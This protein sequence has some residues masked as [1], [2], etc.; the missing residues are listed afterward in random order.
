MN[1][2]SFRLEITNLDP[3][4]YVL[5]LTFLTTLGLAVTTA[6]AFLFATTTTG[7]E[8]TV[9]IRLYLAVLCVLC[10]AAGVALTK[11]GLLA[12]KASDLVIAF[13]GYLMVAWFT[14]TS[15]ES[16]STLLFPHAVNVTATLLT[17]TFFLLVMGCSSSLLPN[18]L[19]SPKSAIVGS[20]SMLILGIAAQS[21]ISI[22]E[23][24]LASALVGY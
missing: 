7:P 19:R 8:L 12:H 15:L 11:V 14:G 24:T 6:G 9:T 23:A 20:A 17:A 13:M 21:Y 5:V 16:I 10:L 4:W 2:K 18:S 22:I 1:G 3:H